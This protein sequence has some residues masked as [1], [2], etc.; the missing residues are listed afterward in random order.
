MALAALAFGLGHPVANAAVTAVACDGSDDIV[1]VQ[2]AI[3][4]ALP[5]DT[6]RLSGTCDFRPAPPHGGGVASID[7]TA[8]LVRPGSP[9]T[10]LIV[11]S[12]PSQGATIVGSGTQTAFAVAPG[13]D[14]V[15]IRGLRFVNVARPI[16]VLGAEGVTVG[17]AGTG[18]PAARGNRIV[19]DGKLDSAVLAVADDQPMTIGYGANGASGSTVFTPSRLADLTVEGNQITYSP[20]GVADPSGARDVVGIDVR[21]ANGG[22]VEGVSI[23][24][25]AV[26]M[27]AAE[28]GSLRHNGVRVEGLA[29]APASSPPVASDYRIH[30]VTVSGNNL[31]RFEELD[32]ARVTGVD[33]DDRHAAGRVGILLARVDDFSVTDNRVRARLNAAGLGTPG[34][35]VVA[36]DSAFGAVTGNDVVVQVDPAVP[37]GADL[38]GVA[39]VDDL[40]AVFG[41]ASTPDQATTSVEVVGNAVG[42]DA[43]AP[44]RTR[45]GI[46]LSGA[47]LATVWDNDVVSSDAAA[48]SLGID[49]GTT[50]G[51]TLP[52]R[53]TRSVVCDNVLDGQLDDP[54][55]IAVTSGSSPTEGNAFPGGSAHPGNGECAPTLSAAPA[56]GTPV[57]PGGALVAS[58][59]AWAGRTVGIVVSDEQGATVSTSATVPDDGVYSASLTDAELTS[60]SDGMLTVVAVAEHAPSITR[61]SAPVRAQLNLVVDPPP[62]GTLTV[63]DGDGYTNALDVTF[64]VL[65]TWEETP[66]PRDTAIFL[67]VVDGLGNQP[68]GCGP[69]LRPATGSERIPY[70]CL[71]QLPE[72]SYDVRARWQATDGESSAF[73]VDGSTKDSILPT[74]TITT[75]GDGAVSPTGSVAVEGT[76]SEPGAVTVRT[77]AWPPEILATAIVQSD[78]TWSTTI[79]LAEGT[80]TITAFATDEAGNE[81][82]TAP[83]RDVTVQEGAE[84]DPGEDP[85]GDD[86]TPPDAPAILTPADGAL[87]GPNFGVGGT[88]E[89]GATVV[90]FL[91]GEARASTTADSAGNWG[92]GLNAWTGTHAVHAVAVDEAGNVGAA[93]GTITVHVDATP[94]ELTVTTPPDRV[95]TPASPVVIEGTAADPN[96]V[97]RVQVEFWSVSDSSAPKSVVNATCSPACPAGAITWE[98][99]PAETLLPGAYNARVLAFDTLGNAHEKFVRFFKVP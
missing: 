17:A 89:A 5:G 27:F 14:R 88:A 78:G 55:E 39:V 94:P 46:V 40:L 79:S 84:P 52:R 12:D 10:D 16:V 70:D 9:V 32:P 48:V 68:P 77:A 80:H 38:G 25:N 50:T 65:V 45:R 58:G 54:T 73:A 22:V 47:D 8:V 69:W 67:S 35:G 86:T 72:G 41:A 29:A 81:G 19:G 60:L 23:T 20:P 37:R 93:S 26:A 95:F 56:L 6:V 11:E 63:E 71:R 82:P 91:D 43:S 90:A 66:G 7:A 33:P 74:V 61:A 13:N 18:V 96:D 59:R 1:D 83:E 62:G 97:F 85:P 75:P 44:G 4:A 49:S 87:V 42:V 28:F 34:G 15:T 76:A 92:L 24:R 99:S 30:D 98:A 51:G 3:D 64:G 21:Q 2:T 53:V 57:E 36:S 31:G